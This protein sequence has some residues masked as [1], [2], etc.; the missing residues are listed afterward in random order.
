MSNLNQVEWTS[1]AS[2]R[3]K[4]VA[5]KSKIEQREGKNVEFEDGQSD[6][7]EL[8]YSLDSEY[9]GLEASTTRTPGTR[10]A[11]TTTTEKPCRPTR[12]KNLV[13]RFSY[14]DYMAYHYA[15][16]MV[17]TVSW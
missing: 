1:R 17:A 7:D 15:F 3:P 16:M 13:N 5:A 6:G 9:G 14:N 12:K 11:L 4:H 10:K 2:E 8:A